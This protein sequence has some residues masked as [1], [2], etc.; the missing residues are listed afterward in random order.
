VIIGYYIHHIDDCLFVRR[1]EINWRP[2]EEYFF[3]VSMVDL[4][5]PEVLVEAP[6]CSDVRLPQV[7]DKN[8]KKLISNRKPAAQKMSLLFGCFGMKSKKIS[9]SKKEKDHR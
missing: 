7:R 3:K 1:L 6:G 4:P 5:E 2:P 8:H 9:S